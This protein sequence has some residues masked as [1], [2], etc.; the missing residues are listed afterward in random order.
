MA[1]CQDRCVFF[2]LNLGYLAHGSVRSGGCCGN[3]VGCYPITG[4]NFCIGMFNPVGIVVIWGLRVP[5]EYLYL[6]SLA[7][8]WLFIE[9]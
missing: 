2:L 4:R 7:I 9:V 1:E 3:L 8:D 5:V 6:Y